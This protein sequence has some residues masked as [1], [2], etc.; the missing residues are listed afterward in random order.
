M[1][2]VVAILIYRSLLVVAISI[3]NAFIWII[4]CQLRS[5]LISIIRFQF[6]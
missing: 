5:F 4:K 3:F 1:L 6:C 2:V